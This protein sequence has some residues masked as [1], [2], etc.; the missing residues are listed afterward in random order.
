MG[1]SI[2]GK[3]SE[4]SGGRRCKWQVRIAGSEQQGGKW[5]VA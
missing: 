2:V 1:C 5:Q 4:A 3:R